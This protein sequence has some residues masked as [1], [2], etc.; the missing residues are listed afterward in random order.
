M[1]VEAC[2]VLAGRT[3]AGKETLPSQPGRGKTR[4]SFVL[5]ASWISHLMNQQRLD[6]GAWKVSPLYRAEQER[7]GM[8]IKASKLAWDGKT[9]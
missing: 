1:E 9:Q 8:D 7:A 4:A 3:G 6:R 2:W 5:T